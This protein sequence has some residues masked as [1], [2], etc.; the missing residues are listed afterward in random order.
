M[1]IEFYREVC[2]S[3]LFWQDRYFVGGKQIADEDVYNGRQ[4]MPS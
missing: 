3:S 1:L 2:I 4:R